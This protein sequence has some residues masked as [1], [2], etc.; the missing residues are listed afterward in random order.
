MQKAWPLKCTK[1]H[2]NFAHNFCLRK[3]IWHFTKFVAFLSSLLLSSSSPS[4]PISFFQFLYSF[5]LIFYFLF[6]RYYWQCDSSTIYGYTITFM[7]TCQRELRGEYSIYRSW[8]FYLNFLLD[9]HVHRGNK[10]HCRTFDVTPT[11]TFAAFISWY[12]HRA[13]TIWS[14]L[15]HD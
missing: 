7:L 2:A 3:F 12:T 14:P 9:C 13:M 1:V 8:L 5:N 15:R 4:P 6:P 10:L 11:Q